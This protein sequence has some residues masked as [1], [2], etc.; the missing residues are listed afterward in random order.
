ML[1]RLRNEAQL[2]M[3][4]GHEITHA[5]NRHTIQEHQDLYARSGANAYISVLSAVAGGDVQNVV[6]GLG[7]MMTLAAITGYSR[8]KET[9]ADHEGL[10]LLAK[11]GYEPRQGPEMFQRMLA[12]SDPSERHRIF[13]YATHPAMEARVASCNTLIRNLPHEVVKNAVDSGTAR[14]LDVAHDLIVAE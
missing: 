6:N 4:L 11:A 1:G 14:Y 7:T 9:E 2:A 8:E 13:F 5:T 10:I 3:L 12:A